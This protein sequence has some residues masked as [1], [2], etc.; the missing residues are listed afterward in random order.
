[1]TSTGDADRLRRELQFAQRLLQAYTDSTSLGFVRWD[2]GYRIVEWSARAEAIFGWRSDEVCGKTFAEIGLVYPEDTRGVLRAVDELLAGSGTSINEHRDVTR[3]GRLINCRWFSSVIPVDGTVQVVSLIDDVS[4]L[5]A[6]RASA[7]E[8][9]ERFRS[10]F[11]QSP[12]AMLALSLDGVVTRANS[13]ATRGLRGKALAGRSVD[14]LFAHADVRDA[15]EVFYRATAGRASSIEVGALRADG[16]HYPVLATMIPLFFRSEIAG[17]HLLFRDLSAIRQAERA[18]AEQNDRLRELYLVA[19]AANATAENQ[20]AATID[21]GCRLLRM[22][23][24]AIYDAEADRTIA[25]VGVGIPRK[26]A[27]LSLATDGALALEDLVGLRDLSA[28]EP[29]EDAPLSYIGTAIEVAGARY[30]A[31]S[32]AAALPRELP[33]TA[34]DRDLVQLM[35]ALVGSAIERSRSRARLKNLA[36]NDQLTT[37]PNRTWFT[38]RL[39]DEL[40]R[41]RDGRARVAV[42]FLDL[43]RFKD[44][45]DTLGHA[46]GDRLLRSIGDRLTAVVGGDGLVARMGGDE[47]I[48]LIP[49]D[50]TTARLDTLAQRIVA[51]IDQPLTIDGHE[52]FVTTSIGIAVYPDDGSDVDELVKNADVAMYRA[53]E[54]GRNTHQFFN[55]SL[56]ASLQ[57]R[58]AQEKLLRKALDRNEFVIHYQPQFDI[59]GERVVALEAL[60]RWE[61]PQ[62][63]LVQPDEFIPNAE[64]SGLIVALGEWVLETACGQLRVWQQRVPELRLAVNLSGR[65]FH[66]P[67]LAAKVRDVLERTGIQPGHLEVEITE[68]VAM[69]DAALSVQI[70]EELGRIGIRR[71]VDDFGTGYSSLGY[72]R[73]FRLDCLKV[74]KSFV[75]DILVEPEDATI[76]RTVIAMAHSLGLEVCA[77]GV[78]TIEQLAFLRQERCDRV[79]GFLF[80]RPMTVAAMDLF[81]AARGI[82][83]PVG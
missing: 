8:S 27:R 53:K 67:S 47:F 75:R 15:R 55:P 22:T 25:M 18:V 39:R 10:L 43:D 78:E 21:A 24:G 51:A 33:F 42:M 77:E 44:I 65:Q 16:T 68:S 56:G 31:L 19:A 6:T 79:Q 82:A 32:F 7:L 45:N 48:V 46:L 29:G 3:D 20:I 30:G 26:L 13:A 36:Y 76:V 38:E 14:E 1:M 52:Q 49:G 57:T 50:P 58:I 4:D 5:V 34:S 37:L 83:A 81:L 23:S 2:A 62:L 17:V 9:E 64:M 63:G 12:D 66:Q 73:R 80:A 59:T 60:V 41:A 11:D 70:L 28:P 69:S 71:A 54:R 40:D 74:D 61:H 72:L 35:G